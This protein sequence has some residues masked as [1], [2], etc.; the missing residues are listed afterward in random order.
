MKFCILPF[1][2]VMWLTLACSQ[3]ARAEPQIFADVVYGH[4]DGLALTF[5][6][7]QPEKPSGA[8]V[9]WIQSGGWYSN[10]VEPKVWLV[11]GKNYLDKNY[12]LFIVRHGSAPKYAIP[13]AT[14]DVR[15]AVRVIRQKAKDFMV[16]PERL[17]VIG[18]SAGG[19][20]SCMLGTTGDDGD[21]KAK[22]GVLT[23]SSRVACVVALYPPTDISEWVTN[24]PEIIKKNAGLKPPLTFDAKLA[25]EHSPLL[26]VTAKSAPTLFIHGE[27]DELVPISHSQKMLAALEKANV[28][29]KLV[30]IQGAAHGFNP[31][32]NLEQVLPA[33]MEWFDKYLGKK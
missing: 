3:W 7:I 22:D 17:G 20:L 16:D 4:K 25:P 24:P 32:Q 6:V 23:S 33:M 21:P 27:K 10:W 29:A 31:K 2:S 18:G 26:K 9:L 13:D 14:A 19:H 30:T 8:A 15:R 28:P 1:A 5:D 12:T 11:A